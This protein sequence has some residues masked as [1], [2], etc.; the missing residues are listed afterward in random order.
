M[1]IFTAHGIEFKCKAP[2]VKGPDGITLDGEWTEVEPGETV[3]ETV[4]H[5]ITEQVPVEQADPE[6]GDVT[7]T[8][9]AMTEIVFETVTR[10]GEPVQRHHSGPVRLSGFSDTFTLTDEYG[11]V[12]PY[13]SPPLNDVTQI[14]LALAELCEEMVKNG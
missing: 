13:A 6:T 9:E 12:V 4:E 8:Y 11:N 7:V 3:T 1:Y 10:P 14:K 2:P 5:E